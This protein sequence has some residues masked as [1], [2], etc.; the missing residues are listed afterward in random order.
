M[1]TSGDTF[2]RLVHPLG[3][4]A[5]AGL[6]LC[7]FGAQAARAAETPAPGWEVT[8]STFPTDIAPSGG[9]GT[10][11][12][13][14]YNIGAAPSSG[15][16]TVT[17]TLPAG[18]VA[19][20][21]GDVQEGFVQSIGEAGLW[22]CTGGK[23]GPVG[24]ATV[25]ICTNDPVNLPSLPIPEND[26]RV[27]A[28]EG[29]GAIAHIGIA[30]RTETGTPGTLANQVTVAGGGGGVAS[31]ESPVIVSALP[32][33]TFGIQDLDGWASEANGGVDVRAGSHPYAIFFSFDLNTIVSPAKGLVPADGNTRNIAVAL[34][35]GLVGN[36][37]AV[38]QCKREEFN[39][40]AC[41]PATQVGVVAA[42]VLGGSPVPRHPSFPV[43]NVVPP[44]GVPAAFGFVL[45]GQDV[46]LE[47]GVRSGGD[48]GITIHV[49]NVQVLENNLHVTGARVTLWGEPADPAHDE[50]RTSNAWNEEKCN[51]ELEVKAGEPAGCVS[52]APRVPFLT[53][54]GSCAGPQSFTMSASTWETDAFAEGAFVSHDANLNPVGLSGCDHLRFG[55]SISA[56]PDTSSADTPAGLTVDVRAPQEGLVTPGALAA[57]DIRD[58]TVVLPAG[59][60]INPGQ[61]AGLQACQPGDEPGG[62]D[63]PLA[64]ENGEE[65]RFDGSPDCPSASKVGTIQITTPLLQEKLEGDVYVLQSNP[66]HLKLLF[67]AS[68]EG[69]NVKLVAE[70]S[71]CEATGE[72]LDGR[73]CE[74]P[75]QLITKVT[76]APQLPFTEFSLKFSGGAQAALDTPTKCG[77]Y[78]TTSDFTPWSAPAVGEVFPTSSFAVSAGPGGSACPSWVGGPPLPFSPS[79]TAGSTTD[80][81]GG[82]TGFSLLIQNGDAEQRI[83]SL[84]FKLPAGLTGELSQ[85]P[86]CPEPQADAGTCSQASQIGHAT[87][88]SGPGPYPLVVPQ[89]GEPEARVFLTGPYNGSGACTVGELGC[90]PFGL[91]IATP[92]LVGPFDLGLN[93]VRARIEIDP[94]TAAIT[95]T[96]DASG[97]HAI[98]QV[99]DGVPTDLR[100]ID[101]VIDR[102]G[103]MV[104]PTNCNAASFAGT[105]TS[106]EGATAPISSHFQVG[107]CQ[108]LKFEPKFTASTSGKTSKAGGASLT[109][110]VARATGPASLQANFTE[111]KI[112][113]P[114][115][116]PSR[117]T[118]LQKACVAK[119][120]EAN[121]A[122]C[123][124]ES[125]IGRVRVITPILPVPLEGPAYFVSHGGEAFPSVIFVLQGY[126]ITLDVVSTTFISKA[127]ITS[128]TIK[129]VPDQPFTSFELTFPEGKF[130]ALGTNKNLCKPTHM[131]TTKKTVR[132]KVHGKTKKVVKKTTKQIAE[133]LKIPTEFIAQNGLEIHQSTPIT[134]TGCPKLKVAKKATKK[135]K[136]KAKKATRASTN[137]R[138]RQ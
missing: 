45:L 12:V 74:A 134:V 98:P 8:S 86:L 72:V 130:S 128:A 96:T 84:Q 79:M 108:S 106:A 81:A 5:L 137:R 46:F 129:T 127:G 11:E 85:V 99:L 58:A 138:A 103:F 120:F 53:L 90:A 18:V 22:D 121:P 44:P 48:Y 95:V 40:Q 7:T 114:K 107:S 6:L 1:I 82:F 94:L 132:E 76:E 21:A 78:T 14:V 75:G 23:G 49:D 42:D 80:Q 93:V 30:V 57:S 59:F 28:T 100:T 10:L 111:A 20:E 63:L 50:D 26:P 3:V 29:A 47:A 27:V 113:L 68:G 31:T 87:V 126:G 71:L 102:P 89:P 70:A 97:P 110:K 39:Q 36:P 25:V 112:E 37:T 101:T 9:T 116:L 83:H 15:P 117:L 2:R 67:A 69:V 17:D 131:V 32:A 118:T 4:A 123:P 77:T 136:K 60:V 104:N 133:S 34:P 66:P 54:A 52:E 91:A 33:S 35:P 105:A 62:D 122:A 61:A 64:G 109:L 56:E 13:N 135:H 65:E 19:V 88:A 119:V 41:D 73:N 51:D 38:P 55:P 16:V 124:S 125:D 24:G 115:A 92:V 43:Y